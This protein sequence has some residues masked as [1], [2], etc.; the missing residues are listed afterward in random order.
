MTEH[1]LMRERLMELIASSSN[2]RLRPNDAKQVVSQEFAV[3]ASTINEVLKELVED[4][5][6]VYTYRDPCSYVEIP[7]NGCEGGHR[8]ARPMKVVTDGNGN[9]WI[10]DDVSNPLKDHTGSGCWDCGSLSFTRSG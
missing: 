5:D 4:G 8:A 9:P 10:C 3:S 7:C 1:E 6:L 2:Q